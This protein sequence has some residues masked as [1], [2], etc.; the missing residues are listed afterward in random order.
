MVKISDFFNHNIVNY[1]E[2]NISFNK[3][4]KNISIKIMNPLFT[5]KNFGSKCEKISY[6]IGSVAIGILTLGLAHASYFGLKSIFCS[7]K[8][9]DAGS[10]QDKQV[11]EYA[12]AKLQS[13]TNLNAGQFKN[14]IDKEAEKAPA[15]EIP[16]ENA[17]VSKENGA[18]RE[19]E[20]GTEVEEKISP[21]QELKILTENEIDIEKHVLFNLSDFPEI[22]FK[23]IFMIG[24]YGYEFLEKEKNLG[25]QLPEK[26]FFDE[27]EKVVYL[28]YGEIELIQLA[29]KNETIRKLIR[30]IPRGNIFEKSAFPDYEGGREP[31]GKPTRINGDLQEL[32]NELLNRANQFFNSKEYEK[33]NPKVEIQKGMSDSLLVERMLSDHEGLIIGEDHKEVSSKQFLI[34]QMENFKKQGVKTLFL[35]HLYYDSMQGQLDAFLDSPSDEFPYDLEIYLER[36]EIHPDNGL[37]YK[38]IIL[39]AKKAGIRIVGIDTTVSAR[40]GWSVRDGSSGPDRNAAMNYTAYEVIKKEKQGSKYVV[41]LGNA[42]SSTSEKIPGMRGNSRMSNDLHPKFP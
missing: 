15:E 12:A 18:V 13:N 14:H 26:I 4:L 1:P 6:L 9:Q 40:A 8:M 17:P 31:E 42:H 25:K 30:H 2:S 33:K 16:L 35:E 23:P 27:S 41:L 39:A 32:I 29:K 21:V 34:N 28:G 22:S 10:K 7:R 36:E 24:K 37:N 38:E 5:S 3:K 20:A 19:E 11:A